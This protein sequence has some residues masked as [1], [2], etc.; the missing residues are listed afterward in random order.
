MRCILVAVDGSRASREAART[1]VEFAERLCM[2]VRFIHVLPERVAEENDAP[3]FNAFEA[4]CELY[5]E[6]LLK[7]A[8]TE[9]LGRAGLADT[10]VV[11]GEPVPQL[12]Q[13]ASAEDVEMV[14]VGA[15]ARGPLARTLLGSVSAE[16]MARCPKPVMV[17]PERGVA[18]E[19]QPLAVPTPGAR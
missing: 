12:C 4:A 18:A 13:L 11:H 10:Q 17:V 9:G 5:A 3:E 2:G 14:I 8:R 16:L 6:E 19:V 15:R 1:A 7:E